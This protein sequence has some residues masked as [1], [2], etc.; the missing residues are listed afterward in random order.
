MAIFGDIL[1]PVFSASRVHQV[2]DLHLKFALYF[3]N[4]VAE[5]W[6]TYNL[7]RLSLGE[8]KEEEEEEE[9]RRTNH[10]M[11][12]LWSALFHRATI[13]SRRTFNKNS[14]DLLTA[15]THTKILVTYFIISE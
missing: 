13:K 7:R 5:V 8:E 3:V 10:S 9:E 11:K 14:C 15:I 4:G 6:Q 2:S 1:R 12:I